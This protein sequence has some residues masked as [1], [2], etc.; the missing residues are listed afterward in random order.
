[1]SMDESPQVQPSHGSHKPV[2]VCTDDEPEILLALERALRDEPYDLHMTTDPEKALE[3]IRTRTVS[4][5]ISDYRMPEMDGTTLLQLTRARSPR[6]ARILLTA[7][8]GEGVVLHGRETG[9][10]T[11]F[12]KPWNAGELKRAIRE[13][14]RE[15]QIIDG[16]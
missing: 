11:L 15:R 10:L 14:V 2:V 9:L 7:Y 12:G 8:P 16:L 6:T 4:V 13:R 5:V 3:W 1:M